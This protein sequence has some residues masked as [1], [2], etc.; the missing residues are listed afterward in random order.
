MKAISFIQF[1]GP[2]LLQLVDVPEPHAERRASGGE[3]LNE[4]RAR[5]RGP[6]PVCVLC[7]SD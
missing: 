3:A 5:L 2:E 4:E 7:G 1:G 6:V